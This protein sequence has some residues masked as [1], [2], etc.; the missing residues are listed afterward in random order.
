[1]PQAQ[2]LVKQKRHGEHDSISLTIAEGFRSVSYRLSIFI[3]TTF[4]IHDQ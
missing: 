3:R 1:M 2:V 4:G